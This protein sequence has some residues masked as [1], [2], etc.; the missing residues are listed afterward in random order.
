LAH[1]AAHLGVD[2]FDGQGW[3]AYDKGLKPAPRP[4]KKES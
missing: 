3:E 4:D 1:V 2:L